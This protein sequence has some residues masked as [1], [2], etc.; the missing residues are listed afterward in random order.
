MYYDFLDDLNE[1][2]VSRKK[3]N[4]PPFPPDESMKIVRDEW[5]EKKKF[6]EL[7]L[8]ILKNWDS[9]NCEDFIRPLSQKLVASKQ[10]DQFK[11]LWKGVIS[12]RINKLWVDYNR[13]KREIGKIDIEYILNVDI[14]DFNQYS[15]KESLERKIAWRRLYI[16]DGIN[17]FML[18]LKELG[19]KEEIERQKILLKKVANL[20]E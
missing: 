4:L 5:I 13:F 6:K 9:G 2:I 10:A 18:G 17:E 11:Q 14:T 19:D 15:I 12:N 20:I 7:I 3:A 8:F 16:I 1:H